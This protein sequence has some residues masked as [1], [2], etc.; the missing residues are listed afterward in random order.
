MTAV[1]RADLDIGANG[2]MQEMMNRFRWTLTG[3]LFRARC[4]AIAIGRRGI[5]R[6]L[7]S[8]ETRDSACQYP[9]L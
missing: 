5:Y 7:C 4:T 8:D 1:V 9:A 3:S 6:R 2:T